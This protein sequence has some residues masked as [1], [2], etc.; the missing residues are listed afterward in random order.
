MK[1]QW[2]VVVLL[3]VVFILLF[4][5]YAFGPALGVPPESHL[6]FVAGVGAICSTVFAFISP[7]ATKVIAQAMKDDD[8]DGVPNFLDRKTPEPDGA[9]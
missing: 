6:A 2:S 3:C 1:V 7:V 8:D 9:E 5:A 4:S